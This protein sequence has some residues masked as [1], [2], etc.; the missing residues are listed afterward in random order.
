MSGIKN[1]R[2]VVEL[3]ERDFEVS[4]GRKPRDQSEFDQW[5]QLAETGLL[6]GHVDWGILY[7]CTCDAMSAE[8]GKDGSSD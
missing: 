1:H 6:N 2:I 3:C 8:A 5:A 7:E 4:M